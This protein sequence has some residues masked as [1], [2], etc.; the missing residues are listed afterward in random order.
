MKTQS[1]NRSLLSGM[2]FLLLLLPLSSQAAYILPFNDT[3]N[4]WPGFASGTGDDQLDVVGVAPHISG[5][6]VRV[7]DQGFID[8]I[9]FTHTDSGSESPDVGDLF[10]DLNSDGYWDYVVDVATQPGWT[11]QTVQ[12][13]ALYS[14]GAG[15]FAIGDTDKYVYGDSYWRSGY[16]TV[17]PVG[18]NLIPGFGSDTGSVV[19]ITGPFVNNTPV[20]FSFDEFFQL[21][22]DPLTIGMAASCANDTIFTEVVAPVPEPTT[23]LLFGTGLVGMACLRGRKKQK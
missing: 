10:L 12:R 1:M 20:V 14:F 6:S 22:T 9:T 3:V 13:A 4:Y 23:M 5:G 7:N 21:G 11:S 19:T 15:E 18:V 8:R 17:N 16:R 2:L